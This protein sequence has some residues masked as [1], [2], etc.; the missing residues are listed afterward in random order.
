VPI[1]QLI[2][3]LETQDIA[4]WRWTPETA[5][6]EFSEGGYRLHGLV[7]GGEPLTPEAVVDG[8]ISPSDRSR[9]REAM[10]RA[11]E[12]GE[13][14]VTY[15]VELPDDSIRWIRAKGERQ[16]MS[17]KLLGTFTD[18]TSEVRLE[19]ARFASEARLQMIF[20]GSAT[21]MFVFGPGV[22]FDAVNDALCRTLGRTS[23]QLLSRLLEDLVQPDEVA[24]LR[25]LTRGLT[26]DAGHTT[27]P[28]VTLLG[29]R[30]RAVRC[31]IRLMVD[32]GNADSR[33][34]V[35]IVDVTK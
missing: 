14:D 15:R 18:I 24:A 27:I 31:S 35:G 22:R 32:G 28:Q 8:A 3:L 25:G 6:T 7:P 5:E 16:E 26:A 9:V 21:P 13:V 29:R 33:T 23:S 20:A 2:D 12:T 1:R 30:K 11:T 10:G 19:A 17:G 4:T 34:G